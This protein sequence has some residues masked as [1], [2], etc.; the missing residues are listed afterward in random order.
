MGKGKYKRIAAS[1]IVKGNSC[2]KSNIKYLAP[3]TKKRDIRRLNKLD[4]GTV[5]KISQKG[6]LEVYSANRRKNG[7]TRK[8][9]QKQKPDIMLLRPTPDRDFYSEYD[10]RTD[11]P[12]GNKNTNFLVHRGKLL[13]NFNDAFK[14]HYAQSPTCT[15]S[16]VWKEDSCKAWGLGWTVGLKCDKCEYTTVGHKLF[17]E[18]KN[19]GRGRK[20]AKCNRGVAMSLLR[21]GIG[22]TGLQDIIHST[23]TIAPSRSGLQKT[24]NAMA[25]IAQKVNE[26]DMDARIKK[27][28]TLMSLAGMSPLRDGIIAKQDVLY[29]NRLNTGVGKTPYQPATRAIH[30]LCEDLTDMQQILSLGVFQKMCSCRGNRHRRGCPANVPSDV[31]I[32][33]E[34]LYLRKALRKLMDRG[35]RVAILVMDRDSNTTALAKSENIPIQYCTQ[36]VSRSHAKEI[37]AV[38]F[39]NGMFPVYKQRVATEK[40]L[41]Q[42]RF[43]QDLANR[44][45]AEHQGACA[46]TPADLQAILE[47]TEHMGLT[48]TQCYRGDHTYCNV[49]SFVCKPMKRWNRPYIISTFGHNVGAGT[50]I[51]PNDDDKSILQTLVDSRFALSKLQFTYMHKSTNK[52]EAVNRGIVTALPKHMEHT[53]NAA[54]RAHATVLGMNNSKGEALSRLLVA[55]DAEPAR[56]S[57]VMKQLQQRDKATAAERKRKQSMEGKT[58]RAKKRCET[59]S[60]YDA[61]QSEKCYGEL[62][63]SDDY[64]FLKHINWTV[65][66]KDQ[67]CLTVEHGYANME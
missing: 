1:P 12:E 32:S 10:K 14:G 6:A 23:N 19:E 46:A 49:H 8:P 60:R 64:G 51:R 21:N 48:I 22:P 59:Y 7:Q 18:V 15:G 31:P 38:T 2:W 36:H 52:C 45:Q 26:Q 56:K 34:A 20:A 65:R 33:S 11:I 16:L 53:R 50:Y 28:K 39:S 42:K 27:L 58:D 63:L 61:E 3:P 25:P 67:G 4:T 54:G 35:V 43:A 29:N 57:D 30:V 17:D 44:C 41:H 47:A 55:A 24:L 37:N 62:A 13:G 66:G 5:V 40:K 9:P